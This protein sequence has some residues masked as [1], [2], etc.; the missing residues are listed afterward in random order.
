MDDISHM[1]DEIKHLQSK[2]NDKSTLL[3]EAFT[4]TVNKNDEHVR[5]YTRLPTLSMLLGIFNILT[6]KCFSLNYWCS[7]LGIQIIE[8]IDVENWPGKK[9][10]FISGIY[11]Y[12]CSFTFG[13]L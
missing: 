10:K 5:L 4:E 11:V 13:Y 9:D 3:K 2:L 8:E 6:A 12:P 7:V 1:S